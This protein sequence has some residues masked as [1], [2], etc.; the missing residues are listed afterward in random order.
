MER[1]TEKDRGPE[2]L[3]QKY[4]GGKTVDGNE[5]HEQIGYSQPK[6]VKNA[7]RY[8]GRSRIVDKESKQPMRSTLL[9]PD[10]ATKD[11]HAS[12]R[13]GTQSSR[14]KEAFSRK[15]M[16]TSLTQ[17][18]DLGVRDEVIEVEAQVVQRLLNLA[19]GIR[20]LS[21]G[22]SFVG[23]AQPCLGKSQTLLCLP[24]T[25]PTTLLLGDTLRNV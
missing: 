17:L 23:S 18:S 20:H 22:A 21:S 14:L 16:A 8:H 12:N 11:G 7:R 24:G 1:N 15:W 3:A 25:D 2:Y 9:S 10:T 13:H 5:F 19:K 6:L 4:V